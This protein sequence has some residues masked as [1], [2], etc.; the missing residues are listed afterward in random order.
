M[1]PKFR[2]DWFKSFAD[3]H[4]AELQINNEERIF[5]LDVVHQAITLVHKLQK[6]AEPIECEINISRHI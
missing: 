3:M 4:A 1:I 2:D 5:K 6:C